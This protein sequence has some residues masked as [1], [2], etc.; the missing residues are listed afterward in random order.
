MVG[1]GP[2]MTG[3]NACPPK[4]GGMPAPP[5]GEWLPHQVL[6]HPP[7]FAPTGRRNNRRT[8]PARVAEATLKR[9][10]IELPAG[11]ESVRSAGRDSNPQPLHSKVVC[12]LPPLGAGGASFDCSVV[13]VLRCHDVRG[14]RLTCPRESHKRCVHRP[15]KVE[16]VEREG[17]EP[18]A[19]APAAR[20][21]AMFVGF[22]RWARAGE[23][24][25]ASSTR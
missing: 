19:P 24:G 7:P 10:A 9:S 14:H 23:P 20:E 16:T 15:G 8:P 4:T 11:I 6:A 17:V 13:F 3:R 5:K 22:C 18:S 1:L 25:A 2:H 12:M 21:R